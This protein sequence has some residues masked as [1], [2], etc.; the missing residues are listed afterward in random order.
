MRSRRRSER[1]SA[2]VEFQFLGILL[3]VPLVYILLAVLD[4]QRTSY[5][6][7]QAAREAGR[8]YAA[9]GDESAARMAARWLCGTRVSRRVRP[10]SVSSVRPH[11][12]T[13]RERDHGDRRFDGEAAVRARRPW[14]GQSMPHPG[15]RHLRD[16][17]RPIPGA[18]MRPSGLRPRSSHDRGQITLMIIRFVMIVVL[19][20][21]T[22]SE[23][24][25]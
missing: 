1:G 24:K 12:A 16:R 23:V 8:I 14:P 15:R 21:Q 25:V 18:L 5:G 13:S 19:G 4:V 20:S 2:I 7:T 11:P 6:V 22:L 9:T 17:G 3:L 10:R